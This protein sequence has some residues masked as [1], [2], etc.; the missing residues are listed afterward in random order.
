TERRGRHVAPG[1]PRS[2]GP[3]G[4]LGPD[5]RLGPR[6]PGPPDRLPPALAAAVPPRRAADDRHHGDPRPAQRPAAQD[7]RT[8][9]RAGRRAPQAVQFFVDAGKWDDEA[10]LAEW[11]DPVHAELGD[12]QAVLVID[13]STFPK[14]G[15]DSCGVAR[16]WCG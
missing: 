7:L 15:A 11:W 3:A 2:S 4:R 8:D 5:T 12:D 16:Q 9:R 14:T 13:A 10:V 6:L 1:P